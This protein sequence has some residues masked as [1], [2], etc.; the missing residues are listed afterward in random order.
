MWR[1][2]Q[3]L[4]APQSHRPKCGRRLLSVVRIQKYL[5]AI[6]WAV[7]TY[8]FSDLL[9]SYVIL[10]KFKIKCCQTHFLD[11]RSVSFDKRFLYLYYYYFLVIIICVSINMFLAPFT[12]QD[13]I[14]IVRRRHY[15]ILRKVTA[16]N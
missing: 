1:S 2:K 16:L 13:L 12:M 9:Q 6:I 7:I 3:G 11:Q 5:F 10:C 8:H 4:P 14:R 15:L